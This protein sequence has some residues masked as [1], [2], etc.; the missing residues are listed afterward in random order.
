VGTRAN[1]GSFREGGT[2]SASESPEHPLELPERLEA[3]TLNSA[4]IAGLAAGVAFIR[5]AGTEAIRAHEERLGELLWS[6]LSDIPG[7]RLYGPTATTARTSV[8]SFTLEAWE[9]TEIGAILDSSFGIAVRPGLHC[10]PLAH[11]TLGTMPQGTVRMS[12]GYFTTEADIEAAVAAVRQIARA[13][14]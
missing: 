9:P 1:I 4:G 10:A 3:G 11:R 7:L 8:V 5:E 2:G 12:C 6:G 14:V 13:T